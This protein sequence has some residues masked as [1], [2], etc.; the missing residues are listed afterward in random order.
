MS[1]SSL[2]VERAKLLVSIYFYSR[3]FMTI[4][5]VMW[6]MYSSYILLREEAPTSPLPS[7]VPTWLQRL[8]IRVPEEEESAD[9]S[10][11]ESTE[12][13][14]DSTTDSSAG[15]NADS[16]YTLYGPPC[17][18]E[19]SI[20]SSGVGDSGRDPCSRVRNALHTSQRARGVSD[21]KTS[22]SETAGLYGLAKQFLSKEADPTR[23]RFYN[24]HRVWFGEEPLVIFLFNMW[25]GAIILWAVSPILTAIALRFSFLL[26]SVPATTTQTR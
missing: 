2:I 16:E 6:L 1:I 7:W 19:R 25:V 18:S 22:S 26:P 10:T 12:E 8:M 20:L 3:V 24:V 15:E 4:F 21:S 13:S 9:E 5:I 14:A 17:T 23:T 11:D